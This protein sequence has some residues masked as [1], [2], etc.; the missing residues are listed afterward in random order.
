MAPCTHPLYLQFF[1]KK[2]NLILNSPVKSLAYNQIV[3]NFWHMHKT[4]LSKK[5]I[6]VIFLNYFLFFI[7]LSLT[8]IAC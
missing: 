5:F 6:P 4:K 1:P 7:H 2:S 8:L 3:L